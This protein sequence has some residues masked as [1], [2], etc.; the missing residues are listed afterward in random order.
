VAAAQSHNPLG[1]HQRIL[2]SNF[3][4]QTEAL[5]RGR[6]AAEARAELE[7]AGYRGERLDRL[8]AAKTFPGNRPTNSFLYPKLTPKV[9]G[10]LLA[11]Y[12]HKIFSQGVIWDVNSFDQMG[13][14]LG[15]RLAQA[16]LPELADD[17]PVAG[18]DASTDGLINA[19]K[20][21]RS[22]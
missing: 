3:F 17:G 12:E 10:S 4:A 16:I 7:A 5:M 19:Y 1:N 11:L 20:R 9:L 21:M 14:E 2:L 13:V 8:V 18:H 22:M 6:T 15:K